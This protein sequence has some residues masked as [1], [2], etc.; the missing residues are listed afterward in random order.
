MNLKQKKESPFHGIC[1]NA[2]KQPANDVRAQ[3]TMQPN[4]VSPH[5]PV[6]ACIHSSN[7]IF[8]SQFHTKILIS[9]ATLLRSRFV[10][11]HGF[12]VQIFYTNYSLIS[13]FFSF[14]SL[15]FQRT[16]FFFKHRIHSEKSMIMCTKDKYNRN[17]TILTLKSFFELRVIWFRLYR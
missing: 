12:L 17:K 14:Y 2:L 5:W 6:V 11:H 8:L 10:Y 13:H 3:L 15:L 7:A 1:T 4:M 9:N 16:H